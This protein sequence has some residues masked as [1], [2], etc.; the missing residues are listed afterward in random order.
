MI[1]YCNG[2]FLIDIVCKGVFKGFGVKNFFNILGLNGI[3][4][5][6]F[7]DG[8]NDLVLFEVCDYGIVMGNVWEE[9]KEK[10]IFI[11]IKNIENGIVNGLKKFDLL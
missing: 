2:F 5:Y 6:V 3:L 11:L 1:F 4:I 10:V 8:I 9:L 7:G